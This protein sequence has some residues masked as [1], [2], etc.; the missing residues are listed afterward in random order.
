MEV[1]RLLIGARTFS[2]VS[3]RGQVRVFVSIA[4]PLTSEK[5]TLGTRLLELVI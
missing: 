1:L 4:L 2:L 3:R 5:L